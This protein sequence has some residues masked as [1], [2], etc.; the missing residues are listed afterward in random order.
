M[1]QEIYDDPYDLADWQLES[2]GRC[3]VHLCNSMVWQS[4]TGSAPPYPAPTAK[5]YT[6]AGLPWFEYYD[7]SKTAI[8]GSATLSKLESVAQQSAAK[9]EAVL[10]ENESVTPENV[11]IF[12]KGLRSGQVRVGQ[13]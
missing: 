6:H 5:S 4:F 13:F 11:K 1:R 9:S 2:D 7:D 3:F 8:D 12:R 10:P